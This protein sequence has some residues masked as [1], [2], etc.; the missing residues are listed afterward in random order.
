MKH[1][2]RYWQIRKVQRSLETDVLK[3]TSKSTGDRGGSVKPYKRY[4]MEIYIQ[5][6][7]GGGMEQEHEI[8]ARGLLQSCQLWDGG[9]AY[10]PAFSWLQALSFIVQAVIPGHTTSPFLCPWVV[11]L[12][13]MS[14]G[15]H[16]ANM[17]LTGTAV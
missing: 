12:T 11:E 13:A 14:V 4:L 10:F 6:P 17:W 16:L 8:S 15:F 3:E 7:P 5:T 2:R 1:C 9:P